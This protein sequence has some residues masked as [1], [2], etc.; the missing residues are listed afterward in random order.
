MK[1]YSRSARFKSWLHQYLAVWTLGKLPNYPLPQ[2][3]HL[4]FSCSL[5]SNLLR[6]HGLQHARLF[7]PPPSP[8][9]CSN[10]CPLS[11]WCHPTI[12]STVIPF[13]SCLQSSPESG[14]F[15]MSW[16]FASG[17]QSIGASAS[18]SVLPMNIQVWFPLGLTSF[19][20]LLSKGL[21]RVFTS[22]TVWKHEFFGAQ[23]SLWSESH[24]CTWLLEKLWLLAS[25]YSLCL[26]DSSFWGSGLLWDLNFLMNLRRVIDF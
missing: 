15:P 7:C 20:S 9:A 5:I 23:P 2:S 11:Q 3:P 22:T 6:P 17:G 19:I 25:G 1:F 21:S 4:L 16:L 10:S 13:S 12:S 14:S 18:A 8:R 26:P 24:I